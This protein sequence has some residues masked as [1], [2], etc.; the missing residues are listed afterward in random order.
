MKKT[1]N[2]TLFYIM[3]F[4]GELLIFIGFYFILTP[5]HR[6][7]ISWLNWAVISIIFALNYFGSRVMFTT[8]DKFEE[9]IPALG[10]FGVIC[11][12][13][14]LIALFVM[15]LFQ[16]YHLT[17]KIQLLVHLILL[18]LVGISIIIIKNSVLF[19]KQHQENESSL[20]SRILKIR[21]ELN[22]MCTNMD[23]NPKEDS[24][25]KKLCKLR[26]S[27]RYLTPVEK[28]E[29][30][31]LENQILGLIHKLQTEENQNFLLKNEENEEIQSILNKLEILL[32]QR[33]TLIN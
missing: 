20:S 28:A 19:V 30:Y 2:N 4:V 29:A 8:K 24:V 10:P 14:S 3:G 7:K 9:R 22:L 16:L 13:Y 15:Y 23:K 32:N 33:K 21:E 1:H 27:F 6:T 18:F 11:I 26:D 31:E 5:E 12:V 17:F 25:Q